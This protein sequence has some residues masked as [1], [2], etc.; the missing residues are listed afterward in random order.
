[1]NSNIC[2]KLQE[3][4]LILI[5][6]HGKDNSNFEIP[7][8][9]EIIHHESFPD[10]KDINP[11]LSQEKL[12]SMEEYICDMCSQRFNDIDKFEEHRKKEHS[13]PIGIQYSDIFIRLK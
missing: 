12:P 8:E 4:N 10:S 9:I 3:K 2:L 11:S 6:I 5:L 7:T 13:A 1:M